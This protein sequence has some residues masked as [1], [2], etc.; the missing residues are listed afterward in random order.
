MNNKRPLAVIGGCVVILLIGLMLSACSAVA[1]RARAMCDV[2]KVEFEV[3]NGRKYYE[4]DFKGPGNREQAIS[5]IQY[6]VWKRNLPRQL[7]CP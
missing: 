5:E 2:E 7:P 3:K 1:P 6:N 4:V